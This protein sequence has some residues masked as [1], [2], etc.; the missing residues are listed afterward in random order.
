MRGRSYVSAV[1][2]LPVQKFQVDALV[3][4]PLQL[5]RVI[6]AITIDD[7]RGIEHF[8]NLSGLFYCHQQNKAF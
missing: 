1:R 8:R 6:H 5:Y 3:Q 7:T 2:N 4:I